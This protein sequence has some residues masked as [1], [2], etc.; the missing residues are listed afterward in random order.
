M[1]ANQSRPALASSFL[2]IALLFFFSSLF[3]MQDPVIKGVTAHRGNSWD[4][5]ENTLPAFENAIAL[6]VDWAELDVH[7]TKDGKLVVIH[8]KATGRVG[9]KD[10]E[11]AS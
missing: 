9:D 5:P 3:A 7:H 4:Y 6:G 2:L 11:V 10:L 8:D 1:F